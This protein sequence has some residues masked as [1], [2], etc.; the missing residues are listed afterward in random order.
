MGRNDE[1]INR[2]SIK[3]EKKAKKINFYGIVTYY[4]EWPW[5]CLHNILSTVE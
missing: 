2:N 3:I 4:F 5:L 1:V